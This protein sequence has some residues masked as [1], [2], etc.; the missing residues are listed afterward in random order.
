MSRRL[1]TF[2]APLALAL[3]GCKGKSAPSPAETSPVGST[4]PRTGPAPSATVAAPANS[5]TA[6]AP[7][8]SVAR[9]A[10]AAALAERQ[11]LARY[12][13]ALGQG[14][15]ATTKHD[16]KAAEAAF[17]EAL[18]QRPDD[19][20]AF[21]ERGYA[22]MLD[23]RYD[24]AFKDL[25]HA[26]AHV[27]DRALQGQIWFNLGLIAE[28]RGRDV[29]A[30]NAFAFSLEA[31]P[32]SAAS[33]KLA[34]KSTCPA[35]VVAIDAPLPTL[36]SWQAVY[37]DLQRDDPMP[38]DAAAIKQALSIEACN[39]GCG[40]MG[41]ESADDVSWNLLWE[42]PNGKLAIERDVDRGYPNRCSTGPT[43]TGK[44]AGRYLWVSVEN[45]GLV[46]G[47]CGECVAADDGT[48]TGCQWC[49]QNGPWRRRD[50]FIDKNA[51]RLV[52]TVEQAEAESTGTP[53]QATITFENDT[54]T[55]KGNGCDWSIP[56]AA[57]PNKRSGAQEP[58]ASPAASA[59]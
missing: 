16:Y 4:A 11:A 22:R 27:A 28:K 50:Y 32:S 55:L 52:L 24:D 49:C 3:L 45:A 6:A 36:P 46:G 43:F 37:K 39:L 53:K 1:L 23:E 12:V 20:R 35:S 18:K 2:A 17:D 29:E 26:R 41:A 21:A 34:G 10:N 8:S 44:D 25:D 33:K 40:A 38:K 58:P 19:A 57:G 42:M 13:R 56:L 31:H 54:L 15:A 48:V 7:S 30:R 59:K 5:A 14:R 9:D 51:A 47:M